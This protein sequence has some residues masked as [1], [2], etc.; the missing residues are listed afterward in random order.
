M[1][2]IKDGVVREVNAEQLNK[3][4]ANGWQEPKPKPKTVE[5]PA[6]TAPEAVT[7]DLGNDISTGEK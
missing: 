6:E 5:K 3:Y 7:E 4:L 2:L 1:L